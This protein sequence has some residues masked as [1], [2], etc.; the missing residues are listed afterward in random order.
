MLAI[1]LS[2]LKM[3]TENNACML[4]ASSQLLSTPFLVAL[5]TQIFVNNL[6]NW[7]SM[8]PLASWKISRLV[9]WLF[10]TQQQRLNCVDVFISVHTVSAATRT[11]PNFTS[12]LLMLFFVQALLRNF[13][14][15]CQALQPLHSYRYLIDRNFVSFTEQRQ[16]CRV[17][18]IQRQHSRYFLCPVWKTKSW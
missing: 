2:S 10:L 1:T 9:R 14:I 11:V 5:E 15:N 13:V 8:D 7:R 16:S 18:L 12:S 3:H 4:C 6:Q 17:C